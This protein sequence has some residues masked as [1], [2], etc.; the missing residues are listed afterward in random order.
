M[1]HPHPTAHMTFVSFSSRP[2]GSAEIE[3][4]EGGGPAE[5]PAAGRTGSGTGEPGVAGAEA[6][7][8]AAATVAAADFATTATSCALRGCNVHQT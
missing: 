5:S 3:A 4:A 1:A 2:A 8:E 7:A 6:E